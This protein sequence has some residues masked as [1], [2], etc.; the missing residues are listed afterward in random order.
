M[1]I[2]SDLDLSDDHN[3]NP[4]RTVA[5]KDPLKTPYPTGL[6]SDVPGLNN[7]PAKDWNGQSHQTAG[8]SHNIFI[9]SVL[10]RC[11]S[12]SNFQKIKTKIRHESI[13]FTFILAI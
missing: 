10:I 9:I 7:F 6:E 13:F 5:L 11:L 4:L 8:S 3:F 2:L 12:K 1:I